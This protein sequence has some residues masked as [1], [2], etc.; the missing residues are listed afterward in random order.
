MTTISWGLSA[1]V[2]GVWKL[3]GGSGVEKTPWRKAFHQ[4]GRAQC[5]FPSRGQPSRGTEK[6][7]GGPG[8]KAHV[9]LW[10]MEFFW[11][12]QPLQTAFCLI[13]PNLNQNHSVLSDVSACIAVSP[14]CHHSFVHGALSWVRCWQEGCE[15]TRTR[16]QAVPSFPA[17]TVELDFA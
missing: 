17:V 3:K 8:T 15:L 16:P 11:P 5:T 12:L 1:Y 4:G 7:D 14:C 2:Q 6:R 13:K 9:V 10:R